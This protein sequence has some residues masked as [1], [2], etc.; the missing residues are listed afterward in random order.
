MKNPAAVALGR[1]AKGKA[2]TLTPDEIAI[3]SERLAKA[4]EKRWAP[5]PTE[6]KKQK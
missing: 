6:T 5:N 4:R 3:R 1:M 2:K